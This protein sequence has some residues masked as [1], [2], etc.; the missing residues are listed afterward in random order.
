M[1]DLAEDLY[2]KT[3]ELRAD[4]EQL[5]TSVESTDETVAAMDRELAEQRALLEALAEDTD[6]DVEAVVADAAGPAD[7]LPA[8]EDGETGAPAGGGAAEPE[9]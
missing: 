6:V 7:D 1:V 5:R 3:N 8:T 4:V 2:A 9:E